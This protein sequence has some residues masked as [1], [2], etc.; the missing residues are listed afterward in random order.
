MQIRW[1]R[2]ALRNLDEEIAFIALEDPQAAQ[3]T[4]SRILEV[5][6]GQSRFSLLQALPLVAGSAR[7][8]SPNALTTFRMVPNSGL[9]SPDRA[10]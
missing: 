7:N 10:R 4:A 3:R 2:T 6:W 9:P 5:I 8:F 1:L